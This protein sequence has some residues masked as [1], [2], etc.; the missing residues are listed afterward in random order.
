M[1]LVDEFLPLMSVQNNLNKVIMMWQSQ[2]AC[3]WIYDGD[4]LHDVVISS[5]PTVQVVSIREVKGMMASYIIATS[6]LH[7]G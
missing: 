3:E 7:T 5:V 6:L 2:G 1:Q 4:E